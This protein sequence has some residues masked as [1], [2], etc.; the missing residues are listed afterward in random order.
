MGPEN[1]PGFGKTPFPWPTWPK[2]EYERLKDVAKS[3]A[4][5]PRLICEFPDAPASEKAKVKEHVR[6]MLNN[7]TGRQLPPFERRHEDPKPH[8]PDE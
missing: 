7:L 2:K 4:R 8:V 6:G 1:I 3:W 5:V